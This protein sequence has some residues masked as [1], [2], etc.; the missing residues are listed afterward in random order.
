MPAIVEVFCPQ[1]H[2]AHP[3]GGDHSELMSLVRASKSRAGLHW[4]GDDR[5]H[6]VESSA[7]TWSGKLF[8]RVPA[9]ECLPVIAS[10]GFPR[11]RGDPRTILAVDCAAFVQLLGTIKA[12][13]STKQGFHGDDN[14]DIN[15]RKWQLEQPSVGLL[16]TNAAIIGSAHEV[17]S[18]HQFKPSIARKVEASYEFELTTKNIRW[19][20]SYS[21]RAA[22]AG[23]V[24]R[25]SMN[26]FPRSMLATATR[27]IGATNGQKRAKSYQKCHKSSQKKSQKFRNPQSFLKQ[28]PNEEQEQSP[29]MRGRAICN[30]NSSRRLQ[31][32]PPTRMAPP[33]PQLRRP[34][35]LQN[36]L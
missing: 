31:V 21:L 2:T 30:P 23:I 19:T 14:P 24:N 22:D 32:T 9:Q 3:S 15:G 6:R 11:A 10:V 33:T 13:H 36:F 17:I 18:R 25:D 12:E 29:D 34:P 7:H 5:C 26:R 27:T 28:G 1:R 16:S 20:C 4:S 8:I 35:F